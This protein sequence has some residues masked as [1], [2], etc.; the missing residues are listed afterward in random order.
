MGRIEIET[1]AVEI[2]RER[3]DAGR[4]RGQDGGI[5]DDEEQLVGEDCGDEV[6]AGIGE[7]Q[8]GSRRSGQAGDDHFVDRLPLDV[9]GDGQPARRDRQRVRRRGEAGRRPRR[10]DLLAALGGQRRRLQRARRGELAVRDAGIDAHGIA[11]RQRVVDGRQ[12]RQSRRRDRLE[13]QRA[14]AARVE[15]RLPGLGEIG[16]PGRARLLRH[17]RDPGGRR[18]IGQQRVFARGQTAVERHGRREGR[19]ARR[20]QEDSVVRGELNGFEAR[21]TELQLIDEAGSRAALGSDDLQAIGPVRRQTESVR[22][23]GVVAV[24]ATGAAAEHQAAVPQRRR[25]RHREQRR[26]VAALRHQSRRDRRRRGEPQ[27]RAPARERMKRVEADLQGTRLIEHAE[28]RHRDRAQPRIGGIAAGADGVAQ[29]DA[30]I[31]EVRARDRDLAAPD[32]D[33]GPLQSDPVRR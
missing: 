31:G 12:R 28:D 27:A 10:D 33:R 1:P 18:R 13:R 22:G 26:G 3:R 29:F 30:E 4:L 15:R 11:R 23:L 7:S 5:G 20:E 25:R 6:R 21:Q 2:E 14:A 24:D 16:E 9:D 19:L 17:R 8:L 32:A